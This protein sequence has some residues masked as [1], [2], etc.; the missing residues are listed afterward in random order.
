MFR[1]FSILMFELISDVFEVMTMGTA[2]AGAVLHERVVK[3]IPQTVS[4]G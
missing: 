2:I 3:F 4:L 1:E